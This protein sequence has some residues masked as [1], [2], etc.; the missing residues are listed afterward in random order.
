MSRSLLAAT[1]AA[2]LLLAGSLAACDTDADDESGQFEAVVRT[3][4]GGNVQRIGRAFFSAESSRGQFI[5]EMIS[6]S[7]GSIFREGVVL[8][9]AGTRRPVEGQSYPLA[10]PNDE[11]QPTERFA[12]ALLLSF[13]DDSDPALYH[14][15]GGEL[16][17]NTVADTR[18]A[19]TFEFQARRE[20]GLAPSSVLVQG[21]F[22]AKRGPTDRFP[23]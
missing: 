11:G 18:I 9:R 2:G 7:E 17:V 10:P 23:R 19:G 20:R 13:Q 6:R 21:S 12:G 15:T 14:A 8:A 4:A 22:E 5:I 3:S 16:H 1:L